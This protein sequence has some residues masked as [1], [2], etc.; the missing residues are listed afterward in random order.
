MEIHHQNEISTSD[1]E[2]RKRLL[3]CLLLCTLHARY[4]LCLHRIKGFI[5]QGLNRPRDSTW[6]W[7]YILYLVL[8]IK[9]HLISKCN[10]ILGTIS[11][12]IHHEHHAFSLA[13]VFAIHAIVKYDDEWI[14]EFIN[15]EDCDN[16]RTNSKNNFCNHWISSESS[17]VTLCFDV[18][19]LHLFIEYRTY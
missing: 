13:I 9:F 8:Y 10:I 5:D 16:K 19:F 3:Y 1:I 4:F 14:I 6:S 15:Q 12:K 7:A 11:I 17:E 2:E 18:I